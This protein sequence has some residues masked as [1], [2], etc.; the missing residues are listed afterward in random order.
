[1]QALGRI[2]RV[3]EKMS[4]QEVTLSRDVYQHFQRYCTLEFEYLRQK[5]APLISDNLRQLLTLVGEEQ[6]NL[7]QLLRQAKDARLASKNERCRQAI[8]R[9][10]TVWKGFVEEIMIMRLA[11]I[12]FSFAKRCLNTHSE[13]HFYKPINV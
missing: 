4:D 12:G 1:M 8:M 11:I 9:L 7:E 3:W 10:V 2:E 6:S 13:I 5:R